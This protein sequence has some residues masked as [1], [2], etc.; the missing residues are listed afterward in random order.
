MANPEITTGVSWGIVTN[1]DPTPADSAYP[2]WFGWCNKT[3]SKIFDLV[4]NTPDAA[5]WKERL[6]V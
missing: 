4:D 5:V 2:R 1:V 3:N 6:Y